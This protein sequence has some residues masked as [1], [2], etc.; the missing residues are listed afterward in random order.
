MGRRLDIEERSSRVAE[1]RAFGATAAFAHV[2]GPPVVVRLGREEPRF[3]LSQ[4]MSPDEGWSLAMGEGEL[5]PVAPLDGAL[6]IAPALRAFTTWAR[7]ADAAEQGAALTMLP[8]GRYFLVR[9]APPFVRTP[10]LELG[11]ELVPMPP[12]AR[13]VTASPGPTVACFGARHDAPAR[14]RSPLL[15]VVVH[16]YTGAP[17]SLGVLFF[18]PTDAGAGG[19]A[20]PTDDAS[21]DAILVVPAEGILVVDALDGFRT[22]IEARRLRESW[23][24]HGALALATRLGDASST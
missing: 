3:T 14:R 23:A 21:S 13:R 15:G 12:N 2:A 16:G 7:G 6:E 10:R 5:A 11:N 20:D 18:E 4:A 19:E 9:S 22:A 8:D 17:A 24:T 1:L